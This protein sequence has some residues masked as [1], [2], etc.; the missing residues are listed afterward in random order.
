MKQPHGPVRCHSL[1]DAPLPL[2][3]REATATALILQPPDT[4]FRLPTNLMTALLSKKVQPKLE[5]AGL[6]L[7][8]AWHTRLPEDPFK[9]NHHCPETSQTFHN[10]IAMPNTGS[11]TL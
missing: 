3:A 1:L 6:H 2:K 10:Q 9:V 4:T 5:S 8:R 7:M 11:R